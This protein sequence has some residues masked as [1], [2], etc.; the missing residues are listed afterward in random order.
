MHLKKVHYKQLTFTKYIA[1]TVVK[2][3]PWYVT[4]STECYMLYITLLKGC[5]VFKYAKC[6]KR[7]IVKLE[8]EYDVKALSVEYRGVVYLFQTFVISHSSP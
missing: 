3:A 5:N 1:L 6:L 4:S 2:I 7:N 8:I